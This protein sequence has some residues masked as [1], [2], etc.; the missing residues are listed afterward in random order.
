MLA[1]KD[2]HQNKRMRG[3]GLEKVTNYNTLKH[4]IASLAKI[5]RQKKKCLY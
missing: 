3:D 1:K 5:S 2:P 4:A